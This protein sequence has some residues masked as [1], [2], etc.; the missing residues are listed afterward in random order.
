MKIDR[1]SDSKNVAGAVSEIALIRTRDD[2][3][4]LT[5]VK[6]GSGNLEVIVWR[7]INPSGFQ[8]LGTVQAG[9][10][11]HVAITAAG[12]TSTYIASMR[13]GTGDLELIAFDVE[14][15][16]GITRT[17]DYGPQQNNDVTETA[18]VS[19]GG[20]PVTATR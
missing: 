5:A 1:Q 14:A 15:N 13:R 10:A 3:T 6:N 18:I 7:Y 16:G 2:A 4:F 12:S 19:L 17:G 9:T 20:R 8:R 11:S